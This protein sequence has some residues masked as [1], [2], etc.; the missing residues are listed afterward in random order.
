VKRLCNRIAIINYG[1]IVRAGELEKMK[2]K[3]TIEDIFFMST[4]EGT[5]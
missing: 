3:G 4:S 1:K 5:L 2:G